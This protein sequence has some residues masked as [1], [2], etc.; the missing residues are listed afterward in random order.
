MSAPPEVRRPIESE[1]MMQ[2]YQPAIG[3]SLDSIEDGETVLLHGYA[4]VGNCYG[5]YLIT[6]RGVHYCDSQKTG[7]FK[8]TYVSRFFPKSQMTRA[9]IDQIAGPQFAYLRIYDKQSK[10][11]LVLWFDEEP[12]QKVPCRAQAEAAASALGL[13]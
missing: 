8:K 10:M 6:D 12:W 5:Y 1:R 11:A 7:L 9:V 3:Q 4:H 2:L 13:T